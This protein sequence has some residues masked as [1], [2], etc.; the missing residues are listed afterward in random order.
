MSTNGLR[1]PGRTCVL[2]LTALYAHASKA[3]PDTPPDFFDLPLDQLVS[4][5]VTSVSK[6][7]EALDTAPATVLVITQDDIRA[8]GYRSLVDVFD[9]LPGMDISKPYGD[10]YISPIWRGLRKDIGTPFLILI[11]GVPENDLYYNEADFLP[12][13]PL[14]HIH[15]I[16]VVYGPASAAYGANA[17]AGV[18]NVRTRPPGE[19]PALATEA[20]IMTGA[21]STRISELAM[22][23]AGEQGY[24]QLTARHD[25]SRHDD[26]HIERY[27]YTQ[28]DYYGSPTLWGGFLGSTDYGHFDSPREHQGLDLRLGRDELDLRVQHY[29][30][31]NGYGTEYPADAAQNHA[32]WT[33]FQQAATLTWDRAWQDGLT[34]TLRLRYRETGIDSR[35]DF[36]AGYNITDPASQQTVRVVDYSLWAVS[37]YAT[38]GTLDVA[39]QWNP[40]LDL[41]GGLYAERKNLHKAGRS[42]Y[43]PSLPPAQIDVNTYAFPPPPH[44]EFVANNR[45]D[46]NS[47]GGY[48]LA[49]RHFD[50]DALQH[51]L[52]LGARVD[53]NSEYGTS[54]T[55]RTG[56]VMQS[57]NWT[58]KFLYGEAF[59]EPPPRVLYGGWQGSGSDPDLEP[60]R[61]DTLETSLSYHNGSQRYLA[62]LYRIDARKTIAN[63]AGGATNL[64][65]QTSQGI[66]LHWQRRWQEAK[67]PTATTW[68]YYSYLDTDQ[69]GPAGSEHQGSIGDS[70]R[71]KI[72]GGITLD[73]RSHWQATLRGRYVGDKT[74]IASNP[75]GTIPS[76]TTLDATLRYHKAAFEVALSVFNLTDRGYLHPGVR[77]A[78]A[79]DTPGT[80]SQQGVWQGSAGFFNSALPQEGRLWVFSGTLRI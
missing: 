26:S 23:A 74:T 10:V 49:R 15:Q 40:Q 35:S 69:M 71:H 72:Y 27:E 66:D 24:L 29:R 12:A 7:E 22:Q 46:T 16:E 8:R 1:L 21:A 57:G 62:S 73:W 79:G 80:L 60:E 52:D 14:I 19:Q 20:R 67:L 54:T 18:I 3:Q 32:K 47:T 38:S 41:N 48:L 39:Y 51:S 56:Y 36:V 70:A 28:P 31:S 63:F 9:D 45:I 25:L 77:N 65:K 11:D 50:S 2:L 61:A 34:T 59:R 42:S 76:Y 64:G 30:I 58:W 78:N 75:L 33:E 4:I 37:N 44:Q 68:L 43:G 6:R 5:A 55:L 53:H 17:F 13:V